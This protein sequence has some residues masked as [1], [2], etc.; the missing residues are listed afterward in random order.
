MRFVFNFMKLSPLFLIS[1]RPPYPYPYGVASPFC[2][3]LFPTP[4]IPPNPIP[5]AVWINRTL[6]SPF[7]SFDSPKQFFC[8]IHL[9][10]PFSDSYDVLWF[11][12]LSISFPPVWPELFFKADTQNSSS[13]PLFFEHLAIFTPSNR[14]RSIFRWSPLHLFVPFTVLPFSPPHNGYFLVL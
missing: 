13:C 9:L 1:V 12:L 8:P 11:S 7:F 5:S 10:L 14:N 6:A 3:A 4:G 2:K